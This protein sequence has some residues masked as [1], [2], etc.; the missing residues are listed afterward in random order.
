MK[1]S[2]AV[3]QRVPAVFQLFR[4]VRWAIVFKSAYLKLT[5]SIS[6]ESNNQGSSDAEPV[7]A[8]TVN[9]VAAA[10]RLCW[11]LG[12]CLVAARVAGVPR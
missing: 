1:K 12:I 4:I 2:F 3:L 5:L 7:L 9:Q 11:Q 6:F 8:R 10:L